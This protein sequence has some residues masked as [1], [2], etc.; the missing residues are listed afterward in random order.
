MGVVLYVAGGAMSGV[1]SA[2][3]LTRL[4]E[5]G[6]H[7]S[8][9]AVYGVSSGATNAAYFLAKQTHLL[10]SFYTEQLAVDTIFNLRFL[11][12]ST[13]HVVDLDFV[14]SIMES[15]V[16]LDVAALRSQPIPLYAK[17]FDAENDSVEYLDAREFDTFSVLRASA[18]IAPFYRS[19]VFINGKAYLDG[20]IKESIGLA[21]I[22]EKHPDD[23]ILVIVNVPFRTGLKRLL[24]SIT[25]KA[26]LYAACDKRFY[27]LF[28]TSDV[29]EEQEMRAALA[30]E[31]IFLVY[32][33]EDF[34]VSYST[35]DS[36]LLKEGFACGYAL[37]DHALS[38]LEKSTVQIPAA[39]SER[40]QAVA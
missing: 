12:S 29:I 15:K 19:S 9:R 28:R 11:R 21:Y 17:V 27:E 26:V 34:P 37:A 24:T 40:P 30:S 36:A 8:L 20:A 3:V 2:G 10:R 18:C 39:A 4:Q 22:K 1:F 31:N 6:I 5:R 35:T 14:A 32:P 25:R 38:F 33:P 23:T 16:P 13:S 7:D